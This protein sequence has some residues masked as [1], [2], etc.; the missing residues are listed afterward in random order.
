[1]EKTNVGPFLIIKKLG[2]NRRQKVYHAR[3]TEQNRDVALKFISVPPTVE[4]R[5][6]LEKIQ[7]EVNELQKLRHPN[8]VKVYGAGVDDDKIFFATELID[9]ESLSSILSRRGK[10]PP[11][12]VV[13]YGR[14]I[15][16]L[17]RYLHSK[18]LIHSKLTPEKI[19]VT[20]D[21]KIKISDLRLNRSKRRR[22]DATGQREL[23]I[24]AYMAPEQFTEGAT[25]KSDFYSL[26]VILYEMLTG[27]LPYQPDTMGRMTQMK[28]NAPVPSAA[29]HVMNCPIWLDKIISQMLSPNPRKRPHTARAIAL[30]F[31]EIKKIDATKKA[32]V[33]QMT[34]GFNPLTAG[35]DQTEAR[36]LMGYKKTKRQK[37]FDTPFFQRV[38][39][40]I[41]ALL[42]IAAIIVYFLVSPSHEK[43]IAKA[44]AMIASDDSS[45][46]GDARS[47]LQP[48]MEAGGEHAAEAEELYFLSRRQTLVLNAESGLVNRLQ[49]ENVQMFG[50]AVRAE[51]NGK[52]SDA[53]ELFSELVANIV[54]DGDERHVHLESEARLKRLNQRELLP[55]EPALLSELISH[56]RNASSPDQL[57]AAHD[58]LA[59]ITME[60]AGVE[61][62]SEIVADA[63]EELQ[64]I[65]HRI[66]DQQKPEPDGG[67]AA[68]EIVKP[69]EE[70]K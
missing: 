14:Q 39:F 21:H 46:W 25:H 15:A 61:G 38:P 49:T 70:G 35:Q 27:K 2:T 69:P 45:L 60:F 67:H 6:A 23:D 63:A 32:A 9:G 30:A 50:K 48:I 47:K 41:G 59:E 52:I 26:G 43:I 44:E 22:W 19:L 68:E 29:T 5:K 62:Y 24:A 1:V 18:D 42:L 28:M 66:A 20:P 17:L 65:K 56:A 51:K 10:L 58:L 64:I 36:K 54:P 31:E 55:R 11:D 33:T 16:E 13:E 4:W 7:L 12:L 40:Q 8:L 37:E 53:I 3:Q 34:G 57:V